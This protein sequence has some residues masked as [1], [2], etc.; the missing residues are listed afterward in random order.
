MSET[1]FT[2][3]PDFIHTSEHL[4]T[5]PALALKILNVVEDENL[6]LRTLVELI[7]KDPVL[8]SKL[9][10]LANSGAFSRIH[11]EASLSRAAM[12]LG[13]KTVKMTAL[14]FTLGDGLKQQTKGKHSMNDYW[15]RSLVTAVAARSIAEKVYPALADEAFLSGLLARIGQLVVAQCEPGQYQSFIEAGIF[16]FS[17]AEQQRAVFNAD[18]WQVGGALL[19]HWGIPKR[20]YEVVGSWSNCLDGKCDTESTNG[21]LTLLVAISDLI[22]TLLLHPD[23]APHAMAVLTRETEQCLKME[24]AHL[25]ECIIGLEDVVTS[26][27]EVMSIE[28]P[29]ASYLQLVN[30]A[31]DKMFELGIE[32]SAQLNSQSGQQ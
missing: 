6:D 32:M 5:P 17:T 7:E 19:K 24:K 29:K 12:M 20:I 31:N 9:L 14:S 1:E 18:I 27:G 16:E 11:S 21:K 15:Q 2:N 3:L 8:T 4:P 30:D 10:K 22:A 25:D 28:V 23:H 13:L 26:V